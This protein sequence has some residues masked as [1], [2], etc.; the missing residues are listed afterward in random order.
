MHKRWD[1]LHTNRVHTN[2]RGGTLVRTIGWVRAKAKI[3]MKTFV[4]NIPRHI[5]SGARLHMG[6]FSVTILTSTGSV[7]S[8]IQ[9]A[10]H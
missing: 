5:L 6:H 3:G 1:T 10:L 8:D 7:V 4:S 2:D 9:H